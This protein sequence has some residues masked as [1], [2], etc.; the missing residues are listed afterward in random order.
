MLFSQD[1]E[2]DDNFNEILEILIGI[3]KGADSA[4]ENNIN[5]IIDN[6]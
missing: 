5:K 1:P 4:T 6:L 3:S 2:E